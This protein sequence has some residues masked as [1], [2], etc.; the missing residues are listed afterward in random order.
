MNKTFINRQNKRLRLN[1]IEYE[2]SFA[3]RDVTQSYEEGT[4]DHNALLW[5]E[6]IRSEIRSHMQNHT[7]NL[8]KQPHGVKA[9]GCKVGICSQ[10]Q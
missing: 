7:W 5:K 2:V 4:T 10:V 6:A 3:V 1:D 8:V 9:I